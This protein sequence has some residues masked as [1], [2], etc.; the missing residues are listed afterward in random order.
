MCR[1]E[2]RREV[3]P[4]PPTVRIYF[5]LFENVFTNDVHN[6]CR[7]RVRINSAGILYYNSTILSSV[8]TM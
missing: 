3:K 2:K 4:E 7:D 6:V 8:K 5:T 1:N